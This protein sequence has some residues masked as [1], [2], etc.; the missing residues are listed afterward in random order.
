MYTAPIGLTSRGWSRIQPVFREAVMSVSTPDYLEAGHLLRAYGELLGREGDDAGAQKA[1]DY[2]M[3]IARHEG[4]LTLEMATLV[5]AAWADL[6]YLRI[7]GNLEKS[8]RAIELAAQ[9]DDPL[10]GRNAYIHASRVAYNTADIPAA[11]RYAETYLTLS[12]R[13]GNPVF[14][15]VALYLNQ[16]VAALGGDWAASRAFCDRGLKIN[17]QHNYLVSIRALTEYET[18]NF[19]QGQAFLGR[20]LD[21]FHSAPPEPDWLHIFVPQ[22]IA[23][24]ARMTDTATHF[25]LARKAVDTILRSQRV[26]PQFTWLARTALALL[27]AQQGDKRV[28][29]EQYNTVQGQR[30]IHMLIDVERLLGILATTLGELDQAATHFEAALAT[31]RKGRY[32]EYAWTAYDYADTLIQRGQQGDSRRANSLLTEALS[33]SDE[34]GMKPLR[35]R[36]LLKQASIKS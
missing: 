26:N 29:Q 12:E 6:Y 4:D 19:D 32:P 5:N 2:V 33:I 34:L 14:L 31:W 20:L 11:R 35:E 22:I 30:G 27:A 3:A 21:I 36:V 10:P 7:Q 25:D 16:K 1:F 18:G 8:L 17:P 15:A 9:V 23:L 28:V 24:V 13:T